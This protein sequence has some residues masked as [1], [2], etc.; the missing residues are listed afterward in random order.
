M[1]FLIQ[2]DSHTREPAGIIRQRL[3]TSGSRGDEAMK[4]S[5]GSKT[6]GWI[7]GRGNGRYRR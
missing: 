2:P 4:G 7:H 1:P 5:S 3:S 6:R